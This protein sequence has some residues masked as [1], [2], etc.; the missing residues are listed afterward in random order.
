LYAS[1]QRAV[2]RLRE[3]DTLKTVFLGTASHELRTPATAIGGFA[4]LLADSW[5]RFDEAERRDM[6][7]RIAA[8]ARSLSAVVQ[9]LLDFSLLARGQ[10]ALVMTEL[11]LGRSVESVL[12][13]LAATFASHEVVMDIERGVAVR[14]EEHGVERVV[15]NLLTNAIKFSPPG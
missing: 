15:T 5:D 3:L 9:D 2:T 4:S 14:A 13:R 11:D 1:Q 6:A 10:A 8:N 12:D 7:K